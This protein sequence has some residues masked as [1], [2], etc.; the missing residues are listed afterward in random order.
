MSKK[1]LIKKCK[2]GNILN[3]KNKQEIS[4]EALDQSQR[5]ADDSQS[6]IKTFSEVGLDDFGNE[7]NNYYSTSL[8]TTPQN[9]SI[10]SISALHNGKE[11][12]KVIIR[13]GVTG[14]YSYDGMDLNGDINAAEN[15][16]R[17]DITPYLQNYM[18]GNAN[19]MLSA[20]RNALS[21]SK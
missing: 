15:V 17:E 18:K 16:N 2:I 1:K 7:V 14:Q 10:W 13:D 8:R 6:S 19:D 12:D 11:M 9:D 4:Q 3:T 20:L 5:L 21:T